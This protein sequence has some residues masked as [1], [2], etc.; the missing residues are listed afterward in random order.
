MQFVKNIIF[1]KLTTTDF[2]N[3][4]KPRN[5]ERAGGGQSY[6]DFPISAITISNWCA[7]FKD[8]KQ[9]SGRNGPSWTFPI[10]SLGVNNRH[11]KITISQRRP[12]SMSIRSQKLDSSEQNRVRAW[13]PNLT[14]FPKPINPKQRNPIYD[15]HIYIVKLDD[16]AY[17]A[18]WFH[19]SRPEHNWPMNES[20]NKMFTEDA[21]YIQFEDEV[22]FDSSDNTWPFRTMQN[23]LDGISVTTSGKSM[24][25]DEIFFDDD[26]TP[27][28]TTQPNVKQLI[29]TVRIRNAKAVKKLKA[30]YRGVCQVSGE[31]YT[32]KKTNGE[33]YSEAHHLIPLGK[34]G[35]DSTH[36]I[37]IIS[38]L[39][40]RMMH[41]ARIEGIDLQNIKDNKLSFKIN[42]VPYTLTWHPKHA[43]VVNE[44]TS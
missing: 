29:K 21:G 36:N 41:H 24:M 28:Y 35:A 15:L 2:F 26:E 6:I 39:I 12:A 22:A 7:F 17:W 38:P 27:S 25:E 31:K 5:T 33:Y 42:G 44:Y 14:G 20:L 18:G 23:N 32:F 10:N 19:T 8:V 30:L 40:H 37:V 34:G 16:G 43:K 3:I 4:N 13:M 9:S 1:R 11:Q